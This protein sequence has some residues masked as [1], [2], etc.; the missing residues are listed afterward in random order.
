MT[1]TPLAIQ[2]RGLT[3]HYR[4]GVR[5]R[6]A[7]TTAVDGVDLSVPT[8]SVYGL[9]GPNGAGKTTTIHMLLGLV[10]PSAGRVEVLGADI[11]RARTRERVGYVP[12][13]FELPGFLTARSFLALHAQ[14]LGIERADRAREI[15][16]CLDRVSL[17]ERAD[18]TVSAFSK[19]MQQRLAIAQAILGSPR[20]VVLDEPT[21]A[22]DPIGRRDVRDLV[23]EL[24]DRGVTV[25]YN[26]HLLSEVEQ[27]C[28][29]VAIL[30]RGRLVTAH[31][32]ADRPAVSSDVQLRITNA[33][34]ELLD[35]LPAFVAEH[36]GRLGQVE[37]TGE[38]LEA[39]FMRAVGADDPA[40]S[41]GG[42]SIEPS[43]E[44]T[45]EAGA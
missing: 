38:T 22:L 34:P 13:K 4:R 37:R 39:L 10:R 28:D 24:K 31:A 23:Q 42:T 5:G 21:S 1:G 25:L 26:S 29:D 15:D 41:A 19:G 6:L 3:R 32:L 35:A 14:L 45:E 8:G 43:L 7:R 40:A 17:A 16:R 44:A 9:L 20:L 27:V 36:G 33:S 18:D 30:E 2:A 11:S 12:E